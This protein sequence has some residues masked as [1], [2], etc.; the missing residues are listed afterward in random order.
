MNT[1]NRVI[2]HDVAVDRLTAHTHV[3]AVTM[4]KRAR[5]RKARKNKNANHGK[6]PNS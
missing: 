1:V 6:R 3:G 4:A 5:K 2:R